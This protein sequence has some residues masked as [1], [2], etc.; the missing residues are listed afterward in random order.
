MKILATMSVVVALAVTTP[1]IDQA[2]KSGGFSG[3]V[4]D[5]VACNHK[6]T[7]R[8]PCDVSTTAPDVKKYKGTNTAPSTIRVTV[9]LENQHWKAIGQTWWGM[10]L[11]KPSNWIKLSAVRARCK[12]R[13]VKPGQRIGTMLQCKKYWNVWVWTSKLSESGT[14]YMN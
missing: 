2:A 7:K 6:S 12:T 9:C 13:H 10:A 8:G 5:A 11:G 4:S 14:Y 3:F 1:M